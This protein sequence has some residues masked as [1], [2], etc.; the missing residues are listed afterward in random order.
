MYEKSTPGADSFQCQKA[1]DPVQ[2]E[3]PLRQRRRQPV[4]GLDCLLLKL[5]KLRL[6]PKL[7][8]S[9]PDP[10]SIAV[11]IENQVSKVILLFHTV[12]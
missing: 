1:A 7:V 8:V 2:V 11:E 9:V 6:G 3:E 5:I 12:N 10:I 4:H